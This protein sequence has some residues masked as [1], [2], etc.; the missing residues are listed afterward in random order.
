MNARQRRKIRRK[1][2][3]IKKEIMMHLQ[4]Y[5]EISIFDRH[6]YLPSLKVPPPPIAFVPKSWAYKV[7]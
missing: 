4:E 3:A 2:D 6:F 5:G 7:V 1:L